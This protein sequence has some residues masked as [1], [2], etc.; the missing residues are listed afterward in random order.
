MIVKYAQATEAT[1]LTNDL[2]KQSTEEEF[3]R[4]VI[5]NAISSAFGQVKTYSNA[6]PA[7]E[8]KLDKNDD[9]KKAVIDAIHDKIKGNTLNEIEDKLNKLKNKSQEIVREGKVID[10]DE[11]ASA[12]AE[13]L[14]KTLF[15][16]VRDNE[17]KKN[18]TKIKE[19]Q[20]TA[21]SDNKI[22][23]NKK[24][25]ITELFN[26]HKTEL[27]A[28]SDWLTDDNYKKF[29]ASL[30]KNDGEERDS[31]R[32]GKIQEVLSRFN[33]LDNAH[34]PGF[35]ELYAE[36][37]NDSIKDMNQYRTSLT[38]LMSNTE[39]AL[40]KSKDKHKRIK[41]II[42]NTD[43]K[44]IVDAH[45]LYKKLKDNNKFT[46]SLL[47]EM[48]PESS[49]K[50]NKDKVDQILIINETYN[51]LKD[52]PTKPFFVDSM[53]TSIQIQTNMN[54]FIKDE[55]NILFA[56]FVNGYL[57]YTSSG[58]TKSI[59]NPSTLSTDLINSIKFA[60]ENSEKKEE[61]Y[62]YIYN[63]IETSKK[64]EVSDFIEFLEKNTDNK[65]ALPIS[66]ESNAEIYGKTTINEIYSK[67][68]ANVLIEDTDTIGRT[69]ASKVI[70]NSFDILTIDIDIKKTISGEEVTVKSKKIK[71]EYRDFIIDIKPDG[72]DYN[73]STYQSISKILT[74]LDTISSDKQE[75]ISGVAEIIESAAMDKR[76]DVIKTIADMD[77]KEYEQLFKKGS[78]NQNAIISAIK[79]NV[80]IKDIIEDLK[81]MEGLVSDGIKNKIYGDKYNDNEEERDEIYRSVCLL[82]MAEKYHELKIDETKFK[83]CTDTKTFV[84]LVKQNLSDDLLSSF[85]IDGEKAN[86]IKELKPISEA[87]QKRS[88]ED[89]YNMMDS[90]YIKQQALSWRHPF[91]K[92]YAITTTTTTL[93]DLINKYEIE[94]SLSQDIAQIVMRGNQGAIKNLNIRGVIADQLGIEDKV[95]KGNAKIIINHFY[96]ELMDVPEKKGKATI[97]KGFDN[98]VKNA[99]PS[100]TEEKVDTKYLE[101]FGKIIEKVTKVE[102]TQREKAQDT[103][104]NILSKSK[105]QNTLVED[106]E[107]LSNIDDKEYENFAKFGTCYTKLF[108]EKKPL[109]EISQTIKKAQTILSVSDGAINTIDQTNIENLETK[110]AII[111]TVTKDNPSVEIKT[112]EIKKQ[113]TINGVIQETNKA[114]FNEI[115][116]HITCADNKKLSEFNEGGTNCQTLYDSF[117]EKHMND[118]DVVENI[119]DKT[120][121]L[122]EDISFEDLLKAYKLD[123]I[124]LG[125]SDNIMKKLTGKDPTI[126]NTLQQ[127]TDLNF[128]TKTEEQKSGIKEIVDK[129][130]SE[131]FKGT[132]LKDEQSKLLFVNLVKNIPEENP[133][134]YVNNVNIIIEK[135]GVGKLKEIYGN[136][137]DKPLTVEMANDFAADLTTKGSETISL[138]DNN[139]KLFKH[140]IDEGKTFGDIKTSIIKINK[141]FDKTD[142]DFIESIY[143]TGKINEVIK[144]S[145]IEKKSQLKDLN[146]KIKENIDKKLTADAK[147]SKTSTW[148]DIK[149]TIVD[150]ILDEKL[151]SLEK[152]DKKFLKGKNTSEV[153][154]GLK[155]AAS[156]NPLLL[157]TLLNSPEK[158]ASI[159]TFN[160]FYAQLTQPTRK[161]KDYEL[162]DIVLTTEQADNSLIKDNLPDLAQCVKRDLTIKKGSI[163]GA[164][165]EFSKDD[166]E[167]LDNLEIEDSFEKFSDR[168][169][170]YKEHNAL[171]SLK[172]IVKN[173][174]ETNPNNLSDNFKKQMLNIRIQLGNLRKLDG[175]LPDKDE[176]AKQ[177]NL[178]KRSIG[179]SIVFLQKTNNLW[180]EQ[181]KPEKI[182]DKEEFIDYLKYKHKFG[183]NVAVLDTIDKIGD[184]FDSW[185]S[186]GSKDDRKTTI[187]QLS[188]M[189]RILDDTKYYETTK[190]LSSFIDKKKDKLNITDIV[191]TGIVSGDSS[192]TAYAKTLYSVIKNCDSQEEVQEVIGDKKLTDKEFTELAKVVSKDEKASKL[193]LQF[194]TTPLSEIKELSDDLK[195]ET[196]KILT[197]FS[198]NIEPLV[199]YSLLNRLKLREEYK[200]EELQEFLNT[201]KTE[202]IDN[203]QELSTV[204]YIFTLSNMDAVYDAIITNRNSINNEDK[205]KEFIAE[206]YSVRIG[207]LCNQDDEVIQKYQEFLK[208]SAKSSIGEDESSKDAVVNVIVAACHN[209]EELFTKIMTGN[210]FEENDKIELVSGKYS[211]QRVVDLEE[212]AN[213]IIQDCINILQKT[214]QEEDKV[215][216]ENIFIAGINNALQY[217]TPD[218]IVGICDSIND[219]I[220]IDEDNVQTLK[221]KSHLL[222]GISAEHIKVFDERFN[223]IIIEK[224]VL[225]D[226]KIYRNAENEEKDNYIPSI[227]NFIES[228]E[229]STKKQEQSE[230][231]ADQIILQLKNDEIS[232][233]QVVDILTGCKT[234]D[235]EKNK[236]TYNTIIEGLASQAKDENV[237]QIQEIIKSCL[238]DERGSEVQDIAIDLYHKISQKHSNTFETRNLSE[239]SLN[240][241]LV[242]TPLQKYIENNK[243][244]EY[245]IISGGI[246]A[247][248]QKRTVKEI[249]EKLKLSSKQIEAYS[250]QIALLATPEEV[251]DLLNGLIRNH[252]SNVDTGL[253][254]E[255]IDL[256]TSDDKKIITDQFE[257]HD[258]KSLFIG[259]AAKEKDKLR[260]VFYDELQERADELPRNRWYRMGKTRQDAKHRS[261]IKAVIRDLK[262]K[263]IEFR[264]ARNELNN[265]TELHLKRAKEAAEYIAKYNYYKEIL[266]NKD[267]RKKCSKKQLKEIKRQ[268]RKLY[269]KNDYQFNKYGSFGDKFQNFVKWA[270]PFFKQSK[271]K[272]RNAERILEKSNHALKVVAGFE[273]VPQMKGNGE[274]NYIINNKVQLN[275]EDMTIKS[276]KL[277]FIN[278]RQ[279]AGFWESKHT[280]YSR[281]YH[282][283]FTRTKDSPLMKKFTEDFIKETSDLRKKGVEILA[284]KNY[285][286][287][288][289]LGEI[290]T[291]DDVDIKQARNI[292]FDDG[293]SKKK[294]KEEEGRSS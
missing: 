4:Q 155:K 104:A 149:S 126:E 30:I 250:Q 98:I 158:L 177:E 131:L 27:T 127:I 75:Y 273:I 148:E 272:L 254:G 276:K 87:I 105:E 231:F 255:N 128:E 196:V 12:I 116:K 85:D 224:L 280:K 99:S 213:N 216:N 219:N 289:S 190:L 79:A 241:L 202:I 52:L 288:S 56:E 293:K 225:A 32:F 62:N 54:S 129:L 63:S 133:S 279:N 222:S 119:L 284:E 261:E 285:Y 153:K 238:K 1:G 186:L 22:F 237:E 200:G 72:R 164:I 29:V 283:T 38:G 176:R 5:S 67:N 251:F 3:T 223:D 294:K 256:L 236:S 156:E 123:G 34:K 212:T 291:S 25:E 262:D 185:K 268:F 286:N 74:T 33:D 173:A 145:E 205:T 257:K 175:V 292:A 23:E 169:V 138:Y 141:I 96:D 2:D 68:L 189:V 39:D 108:S 88:L 193:A 281:F 111:E 159:K 65:A 43:N 55:N 226:D 19:D 191:N 134:E 107:I 178:I 228:I 92:L 50:F 78:A 114:I 240:K 187:N 206:A 244:E 170:G 8:S 135:F 152:Q 146:A 115:A 242:E 232:V 192:E 6:S 21:F 45:N 125:L 81:Q 121:N 171:E 168:L 287:Q 42:R 278:Q 188:S 9:N 151:N 14:G 18:K 49:S 11:F 201:Q 122:K 247:K 218:V 239:E 101:N 124:S 265:F 157:N 290:K 174:I 234:A 165:A 46:D 36:M 198:S 103:I 277:R 172:G 24:K 70:K 274:R 271:R 89:I 245:E 197:N 199:Q 57:Q 16:T 264:K 94:A 51:K 37:S 259:D 112:D 163:L 102:D 214:D 132:A 209:N 183:K 182:Q 91:K 17:M 136:K 90:T 110:I 210:V 211:P 60:V 217:Q 28:Y 267:K 61:I 10:Y 227:Y 147:K 93:D 233:D 76:E 249:L 266:D 252:N 143:K 195:K 269:W 82:R 194:V 84:K 120:K 71:D 97:K 15:V 86:T 40:D 154:E 203:N 260:D 44:N 26:K 113:T 58:A 167:R 263:D 13:A 142:T 270:L 207:E 100:K 243:Q 59:V 7:V 140:F 208:R 109:S 20:I 69:Y 66:Y 221:I 48:Y 77:K 64:I 95:E 118:K 166:I 235:K 161:L 144:V 83:T 31:R 246:L 275:P 150:T 248:K 229:N 181:K 41:S 53:E 35:L 204:K 220:D 106:I 215:N 179:N 162:R 253:T 80:S 180:G 73:D 282:A 184:L 117:F 130:K 137:E 160:D 258:L 139:K 47:V 230:K